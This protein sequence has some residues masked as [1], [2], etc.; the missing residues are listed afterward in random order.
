MI[1][2]ILG[3]SHVFAISNYLLCSASLTLCLNTRPLISATMRTRCRSRL[4]ANF[5]QLKEHRR[6]RE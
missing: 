5:L 6:G 1:I 4:A 3:R 2:Q